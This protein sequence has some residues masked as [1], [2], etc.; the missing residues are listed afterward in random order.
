MQ[1]DELINDLRYAVKMIRSRIN[2]YSD[3]IEREKADTS[4]SYD[5]GVVHGLCVA[6]SYLRS[7]TAEDTEESD[8]EEITAPTLAEFYDG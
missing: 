6:L 8:P 4:I 7:I 1:K 3:L 5:T 2:D